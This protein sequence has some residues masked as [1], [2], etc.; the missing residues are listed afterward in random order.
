M[1]TLSS[2]CRGVHERFIASEGIDNVLFDPVDEIVPVHVAGRGKLRAREKN[3]KPNRISA[4]VQSP[5]IFRKRAGRGGDR[6][7]KGRLT[8]KAD[9][10]TFH[11]PVFI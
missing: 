5:Q 3:D 2:G 4:K 10:R 1:I 8:A 7:R 9:D 6:R 11:K